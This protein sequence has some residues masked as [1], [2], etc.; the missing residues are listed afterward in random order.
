MWTNILSAITAILDF[1]KTL[2]G[3]SDKSDSQRINS[4]NKNSFNNVN[5]NNVTTNIYFGKEKNDSK[6]KK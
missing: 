3:G 4:N 2:F 5:S 6:H 1:F